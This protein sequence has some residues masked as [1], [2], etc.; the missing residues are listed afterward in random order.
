PIPPIRWRRQGAVA[1]AATTC[2][3]RATGL[4]PA[5]TGST[6]RRPDSTT[7]EDDGQL[8]RQLKNE[9]PT[10]VPSPHGAVSGPQFPA[11]L[12]Q[13]IA[14][15]DSLPEAIKAGIRALVRAVGGANE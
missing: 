8:G 13:V 7:P 1:E 9:V 15:W 11:D 12:A 14:A 10:V 6:V 5:T 3:A 2:S 4:E